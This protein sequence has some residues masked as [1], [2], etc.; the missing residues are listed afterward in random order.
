MALKSEN[1][2]GYSN[3]NKNKLS[4]RN[5]ID[6]IDILKDI[7]TR[8]ILVDKFTYEGLEMLLLES[9]RSFSSTCLEVPGKSFRVKT[10]LNF[11]K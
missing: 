4:L 5:P 11:F 1:E 8:Y 9:I 2:D 6:K 10:L 7:S 3:F